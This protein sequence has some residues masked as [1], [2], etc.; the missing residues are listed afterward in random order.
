MASDGVD[1]P[2]GSS[3]NLQTP[4][5]PPSPSRGILGSLRSPINLLRS[6][7]QIGSPFSPR[8]PFRKRQRLFPTSPPSL[9]SG[10]ARGGCCT[11]GLGRKSA[12]QGTILKFYGSSFSDQEEDDD[13]SVV[14][15]DAEVAELSLAD[16][17]Y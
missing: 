16:L 15:G 8:S 14:G 4:L 7:F 10:A 1:S 12:K 17:G 2:R 11:A 9:P 6:P 3:V 13:E 5:L